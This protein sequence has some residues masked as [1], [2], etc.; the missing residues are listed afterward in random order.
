MS[1]YFSCVSWSFF[2]LVMPKPLVITQTSLLK[3]WNLIKRLFVVLLYG[4]FKLHIFHISSI[5]K[6]GII[7]E[8]IALF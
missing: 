1:L 5:E 2:G 3:S 4:S 8:F 6:K 7:V